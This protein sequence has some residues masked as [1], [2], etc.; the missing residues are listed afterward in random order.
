LAANADIPLPRDEAREFKL[1]FDNNMLRPEIR[2]NFQTIEML[3]IAQAYVIDDA[4]NKKY[5]LFAS[6]FVD[7][8]N[9]M[10]MTV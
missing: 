2:G 3:R 4:T 8:G 1:H 5:D 9:G 6:K 10:F 7:L